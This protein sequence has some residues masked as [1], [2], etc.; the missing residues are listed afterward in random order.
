MQNYHTFIP[1]EFHCHEKIGRRFED[2]TGTVTRLANHGS[3]Y[4]INVSSRSGFVFLVGKYTSGGFISIP[5]FNVGTDLADYGD[6]F[7]NNER[8]ASIMN[9]VDAVTVAEAL[10][11]LKVHHLI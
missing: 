10:R 11:A 5:A 4:E 8:L 6:Y 7:W 1:I 9:R 2:W 3:H